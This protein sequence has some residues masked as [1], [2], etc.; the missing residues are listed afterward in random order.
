MVHWG[1]NKARRFLEVSVLVEG[2]CKGVI[3]L[4]EGRF[5]RGW[6]RFVGKLRLLL[7]NQSKMFG[8]VE[9]GAPSPVRILLEA[10][11]SGVASGRSFVDVLR[12]SPGVEARAVDLMVY[13]SRSLDLFSVSSCFE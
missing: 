11:G 4:P 6:W 3:W 2:G 9:L 13:Y 12:S 5:G 10:S 7:K 1:G 8:A